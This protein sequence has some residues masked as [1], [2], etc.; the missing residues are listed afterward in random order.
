MHSHDHRPKDL[1]SFYTS[2]MEIGDSKAL[3]GVGR[4][5]I[6]AG[7]IE[8]VYSAIKGDAHGAVGGA[9]LALTGAGIAKTG[10]SYIEEVAN[11]WRD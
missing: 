8:G 2:S 11:R 5:M 9:V 6:V 10:T 1:V 7:L 3:R 4:L